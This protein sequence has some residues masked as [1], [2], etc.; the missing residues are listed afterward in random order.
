M[1]RFRPPRFAAWIALAAILLSMVP[2]A[3]AR[4]HPIASILADSDYCSTA[5]TKTPPPALPSP[6]D[7]SHDACSHCD[8][9]TG[10]AGNGVALPANVATTSDL[11]AASPG[12][13]NFE[14][15]APAPADLIAA[16]P[17]G[18]PHSA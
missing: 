13:A 7:H 2:P 1:A 10:H 6:A 17:R 18:P 9:C 11:Q 15:P 5:R 8:G 14:V 4:D 12:I 3:G 16:P